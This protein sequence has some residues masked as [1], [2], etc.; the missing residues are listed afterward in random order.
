MSFRFQSTLPR[1][2]RPIQVIPVAEADKISIHAPTRGATDSVFMMVIP[3]IFQ[4]TLPRGERRRFSSMQQR[5]DYFNPRSHEGSDPA[6]ST[7]IRIEFISIHAPT[8]GATPH[9]VYDILLYQ[10]QSTLPRGERRIFYQIAAGNRKFQSTLPRGE[11]QSLIPSG[12]VSNP[13]SIHA[14]TRG[15]TH[16][17]LLLCLLCPISIHA[18]TRGATSM[19]LLKK[20]CTPI[21]IHAPTRGAT[22][23][24]DHQ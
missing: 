2:E 13:I 10:F 8:R 19:L 20:V 22:L 5:D 4:S 14:P 18:P 24:G 17:F 21:S 11:R 7:N 15:A 1:G 16:V 6:G 3:V 9:V 23:L 12:A